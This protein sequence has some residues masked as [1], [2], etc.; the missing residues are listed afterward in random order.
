MNDNI[1]ILSNKEYERM[2]NNGWRM[3]TLNGVRNDKRKQ[4]EADLKERYSIIKK[5]YTTTS[6]RGYY[7]EVWACKK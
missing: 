1:R 3:K 5:Y 2:S 6:V 7:N 4:Q